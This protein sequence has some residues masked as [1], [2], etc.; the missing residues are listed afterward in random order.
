MKETEKNTH[1]D[2]SAHYENSSTPDSNGKSK[3]DIEKTASH[4]AGYDLSHLPI[5]EHGEY[6]VTM[7]TWA[8]VVVSIV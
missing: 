1:H 3:D 4:G 2:D 8:V 7:K 6:K 5:D